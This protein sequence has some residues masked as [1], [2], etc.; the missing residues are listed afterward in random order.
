MTVESFTFCPDNLW[1]LRHA[2]GYSRRELGDKIGKGQLTIAAYEQ[3]RVVPSTTA[4]GR[5]AAA[6]GCP[7]DALF[8]A[9]V[10][11]VA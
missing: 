3:G 6:L 9:Q 2:A 1:E 8:R 5:L 11:Y 10:S 4:V 7:I